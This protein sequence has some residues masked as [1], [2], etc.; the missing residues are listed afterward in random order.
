VLGVASWPFIF[1][2]NIP[3]GILGMIA[4]MRLVPKLH[5]PDPGKFD[6]PGFALSAVAITAIVFFAETFGVHL[7]P[8]WAEAVTVVVGAAASI[9]FIRHALKVEKPVLNIRLFAIPTFAASLT[10]GTLVRLGIGATPL[11]LP[12]LLHGGGRP[13][14]EG[15]GADGD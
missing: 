10:G 9:A 14:A 1:Y 7:V 4:V 11:L 12:L 5:Q 13:V 6:T 2:I 3:I 15:W 8:M